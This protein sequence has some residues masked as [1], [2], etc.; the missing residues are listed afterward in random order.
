MSSKNSIPLS[1]TIRGREGEFE[2]VG[3]ESHSDL[4]RHPLNSPIPCKV[5]GI[6][7]RKKGRSQNYFMAREELWHVGDYGRDK[8]DVDNVIYYY[9]KWR[10]QYK[11]KFVHMRH[12]ENDEHL[13]FRS[14][15]RFDEGYRRTLKSRMSRMKD[16]KWDVKLEITLDPKLFLGLYD[17]FIFLPK[18]WNI[19]NVWLKRTY[20][21]FG[22]LRILEITKKGRPHLHVLLA[23]YDKKMSKFFRSMSKRDKKRR[24][25][26]FY[27]EFKK[28]VNR[29]NGGHVW[30]KPI[31]GSLKLVNYVLKYVNKTISGKNKKY[32]AL[33]FATNRRLFSV[34]RDLRIFAKPKK[35]IV[36]YE[37]MGCIPISKLNTFCKYSGVPFGFSIRMSSVEGKLF[38]EGWLDT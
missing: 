4:T 31:K 14:S 29:N 12:L 38:D 7:Q 34:S 15:S 28:V 21:K 32:S 23:F 6:I 36:E 5:I 22:F 8:L 1:Q 24:F 37:Y 3:V 35:K 10:K 33:L 18:L 27:A 30:V 19:V 9:E 26:T 13:F 17:Q 16:I 2:G 11:D 20:G 25:Q